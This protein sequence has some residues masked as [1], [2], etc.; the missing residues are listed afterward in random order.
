M[1][2]ILYPLFPLK[3]ATSVSFCRNPALPNSSA[4]FLLRYIWH[5]IQLLSHILFYP[6]VTNSQISILSMVFQT[7]EV[8]AFVRAAAGRSRAKML[9]T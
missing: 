8:L 6:R 4:A 2:I 9:S 1:S 7:V 5:C 3:N